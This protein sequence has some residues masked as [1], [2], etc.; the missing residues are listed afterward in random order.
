M[1]MPV[2]HRNRHARMVPAPHLAPATLRRRG[3][4]ATLDEGGTQRA[5]LPGYSLTRCPVRHAILADIHANAYA[6]QAAL[7]DAIAQRA[8]SC[9]C[10]G[11]L[12]GYHA[13]PHE[14]IALMR[15]RGIK[16]VV[17]NHDRMAYSATEA[18]SGGPLARAA[19]Q[20]TRRVL[21]E[22]EVAYLASLPMERRFCGD[23]LLVHSTP[24]SIDVRLSTPADFEAAARRLKAT[25]PWAAICFTG[26]THVAAVTRVA[27]DGTV[28]PEPAAPRKL[29]KG[30]IWFVN[31]GS[32]GLPRD[33]A[34]GAR[35][36]IYDDT[37]RD[38]E[39]HIAP[40]SM[41]AMNQANRACGLRTIVPERTHE[42][43]VAV[44]ASGGPAWLRKWW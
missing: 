33:G 38:V 17:G 30:G 12:V 15:E 20:W 37:S 26:H 4:T 23:A 6:L 2:T 31:P 36:A 39:F 42:T 10:L 43:P 25:H 40:Y 41:E 35:Y 27:G 19:M 29:A 14:T 16:S 44:A 24:W 18:P 13:L 8:E 28:H 1:I 21:Q 22:D 3:A 5:A 32:V 7:D 9:V 11:D 34:A